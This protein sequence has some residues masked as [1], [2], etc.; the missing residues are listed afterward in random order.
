MV[1][2]QGKIFRL[3]SLF[4]VLGSF[5]LVNA[6][7]FSLTGTSGTTASTGASPDSSVD[8]SPSPT[9]ARVRGIPWDE[10]EFSSDYGS[11][12]TT[13]DS[14]VLIVAPFALFAAFVMSLF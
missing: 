4:I 5:A 13:S 1:G 7:L 9:S 8:G 14:S 11:P 10:V 6:Q 12:G 3:I 2:F